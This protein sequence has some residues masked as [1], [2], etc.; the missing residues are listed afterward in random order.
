MRVSSYKTNKKTRPKVPVAILLVGILV[1]LALSTKG[2][3]SNEPVDIKNAVLPPNDVADHGNIVDRG[4]R[5][6]AVSFMMKSLYAR[7]LE[8]I[9]IDQTGDRLANELDM[10]VRELA[11]KLKAE[12]SFVWLGRWLPEKMADDILQKGGAGIYA[13]QEARRFYPAHRSGAHVVGFLEENNGLAGVEFSYDHLL[14]SGS[15]I[16]A[17]GENITGHLQLTLDL[18]IQELLAGELGQLLRTTE[19]PSGSGIMMN[20]KTGAILAMVSLPDYDPNSYWESSGVVRRNRAIDSSIE[21]GGFQ[22]FFDL[23]AAYEDVVG[24]EQGELAALK[25]DLRQGSMPKRSGDTKWFNRYGD[26]LLSPEFKVSMEEAGNGHT[27]LAESL[28]LF[29]STGVDLPATTADFSGQ[30]GHTSPLKLLTAFAPLVNGG[31]GIIPHLGDAIIDPR[32]GQRVAIDHPQRP[33]LVKPWTSKKIVKLLA[34]TSRSG[35]ELLVLESMWPVA[36][37]T[38]DVAGETSLADARPDRYQTVMLGLAPRQEPEFA[39]MIVLDQAVVGN[40]TKTPMRS[41]SEA[42]IG[43]M[44]SMA[45][46]KIVPPNPEVMA[47]SEKLLYTEWLA[48][49]TVEKKSLVAAN[50]PIRTEVMPDLVGMSLRK[51]LRDLQ[52]FG[53]KVEVVGSGRVASQQP[54]PGLVISEDK[55]LLTL[56]VDS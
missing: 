11:R 28:G 24:G 22:S 8:I 27:S 31:T 36:V 4:H 49:Q 10:D 3:L 43:R 16:G 6:L 18:R 39:L 37:A 29:S 47:A 32:S 54:P 13:V 42:V 48:A 1:I 19:A 53:L 41:A 21:V 44:I 25:M 40:T 45:N 38:E 20:I 7:P 26:N 23:A 46:E 9:D 35:A 34:D 12:R 56:R 50:A 51:A 30:S 33:G 17:T 52:Q 5:E 55:C 2:G 15:T 14:R